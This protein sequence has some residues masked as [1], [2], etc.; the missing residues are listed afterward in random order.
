M[1]Y[2]MSGWRFLALYCQWSIP[3]A[4]CASSA[5]RRLLL[6]ETPPAEAGACRE[7]GRAEMSLEVISKHSGQA[8][9]NSS[10]I[11]GT[12]ALEWTTFHLRV[13]EFSPDGRTL[14]S[15]SL[16]ASIRLWRAPLWEEIE[17]AEGVGRDAV[18]LPAHP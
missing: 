17:A 4:T 12:L 3:G 11:Q 15:A 5:F 14:M 9:W 10:P 6:A 2:V 18:K 8:H 13:V 1:P 16:D 7:K